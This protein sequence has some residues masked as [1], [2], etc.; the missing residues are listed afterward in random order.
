MK[1]I[2]IPLNLAL[3]IDSDE[4]RGENEQGYAVFEL[5]TDKRMKLIFD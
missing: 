5:I 4:R 1:T 3:V 2:M